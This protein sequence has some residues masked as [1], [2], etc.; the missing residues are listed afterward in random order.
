MIHFWTPQFEEFVDQLNTL[1]CPRLIVKDR[2]ANKYTHKDVLFEDDLIHLT[3]SKNG[4]V[5]TRK[6][7]TS[8][9]PTAKHADSHCRNCQLVLCTLL[10]GFEAVYTQMVVS[11]PDQVLQKLVTAFHFITK[12]YA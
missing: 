9:A 12:I 3:N 1:H 4:A 7:Q 5:N 2:V 6:A 8:H 11:E 10:T